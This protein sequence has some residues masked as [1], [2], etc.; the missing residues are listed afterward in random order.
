MLKPGRTSAHLLLAVLLSAPMLVDGAAAHAQQSVCAA[1]LD[2]RQAQLDA[3][4]IATA[5]AGG[6]NVEVIRQCAGFSVVVQRDV[7]P[8]LAEAYATAAE[9]AYNRLAAETGRTLSPRAV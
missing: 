4:G 8:E 7:N 2:P 9:S 6:L 5:N 1:P 3:S